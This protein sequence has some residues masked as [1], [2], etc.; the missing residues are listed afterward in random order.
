MGSQFIS[1][2]AA[3]VAHEAH[4]EAHTQPR[5]STQLVHCHYPNSTPDKSSCNALADSAERIVS[6][7]HDKDHFVVLLVKVQTK[8]AFI[9]DGLRRSLRI[10]KEHLLTV[11]KCTKL[12]SRIAPCQYDI[13]GAG[14]RIERINLNVDGQ[15][16]TLSTSFFTRQ[17]DAHNCGPIAAMK[18]KIMDL[19]NCVKWCMIDAQ[20]LIAVAIAALSLN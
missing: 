16:W 20:R 19:F 7:L 15:E 3:L 18:P 13:T 17:A 8:R 1:G 5:P 10:F 2:F 12:V 14:S 4:L 9:F 11:L 6:V